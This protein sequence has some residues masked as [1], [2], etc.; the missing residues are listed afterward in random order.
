LAP[1]SN[2]IAQRGVVR[3][4]NDCFL[5]IDR[6]RLPPLFAATPLSRQKDAKGGAAVGRPVLLFPDTFTE[7]HEPEVGLAALSLLRHAGCRVSVGMPGRTLLCCGRPLI[8]NGLLTGAVANAEHNIDVLYP[9]AAEGRPIVA[10]EPS[11][12]LT[13]KDDY[14]ALVRGER[15]R[16]AEVVAAACV[17]FEECL[18]RELK[19]GEGFFRSSARKVL[20]HGHCHQQA[21]VGMA[22][23]VRLLQRV[24]ETEVVCLDTGCCGMAGSFGYEKEHYEISRLVGEQRLF[25]AVKQASAETALVATGISCRLQIQH[26]T[27]RRALHPA[28]YL[29]PLVDRACGQ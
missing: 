22:P 19:Q 2:W 4:F 17:T 26:F 15:Q 13:I 29:A 10:C 21:L 16:Q 8:S 7:Y 18:E 20:V 12:L 6:R 5:G 25:P 24:P 9:W 14:P 28:A 23:T 27:G 1:L 11:C 3:W